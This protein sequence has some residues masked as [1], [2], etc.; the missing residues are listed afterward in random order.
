MF[1]MRSL[2]SIAC[3]GLLASMSCTAPSASE[4][5]KDAGDVKRVAGLPGGGDGDQKIQFTDE[6]HGWLAIGKTLWRTVDVGKTWQQ[7]NLGE[8]SW[9]VTSSIDELE[10]LDSQTGWVLVSSDGIYGTHDAG[11]TWEK[12]TDPFDGVVHSMK[13][14]KDGKQGWAAGETETRPAKLDSGSRQNW[15]GVISHTTDGGKTWRKQTISRA[16]A[17]AVFYLYFPDETHGWALVRMGL[18]YLDA[19]SGI[20]RKTNLKSGECAATMLRETLNPGHAVDYEPSVVSFADSTQGW[21][22]FQNGFLAGTTDGGRT[23]CDLLNPRTLW[24]DASWDTYFAKLHFANAKQGWALG[25]DNS[26]YSS[27]DSGR[28]WNR[29]VLKT[30]FVDMCFTAAGQGWAVSEDG[31]FVINGPSR[32]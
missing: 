2:L 16:D 1:R 30:S 25:A 21:L 29:V 4:A 14:F 18:F 5:S 6:S 13:F 8:P 32:K 23:W 24:P 26:L 9:G 22:G 11:G 12:L 17:E 10:F 31:I 28:T 27:D 7:V 3:C 19:E 20:W 15:I